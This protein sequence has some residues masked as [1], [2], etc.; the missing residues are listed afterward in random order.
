VGSFA[1]LF[2][3]CIRWHSTNV[4]SLPIV[5]ATALSKETLSVPRY[6]FTLNHKTPTE[7]RYVSIT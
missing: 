2:V 4:A 1:S 6:A 3:E 5:S 7:S